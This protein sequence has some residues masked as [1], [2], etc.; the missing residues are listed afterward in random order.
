MLVT[1]FVIIKRVLRNIHKKKR[2]DLTDDFIDDDDD[3]YDD[4]D[5]DFDVYGNNPDVIK[6][7]K[8][9]VQNKK[10]KKV[11]QHS[12]FITFANNPSTWF[13]GNI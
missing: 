11:K 12:P 7:V 6:V 2:D 8:L 4:D 5:D 9:E 3:D 10:Y 1:Y 13:E